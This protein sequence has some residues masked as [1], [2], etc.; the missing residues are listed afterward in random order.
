MMEQP[1]HDTNHTELSAQ[2][3]NEKTGTENK[4]NFPFE[5]YSIQIEFMKALYETLNSSSIGFFESPTGTVIFFSY[6]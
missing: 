6:F 3:K 5:A 2:T 1:N 4:F